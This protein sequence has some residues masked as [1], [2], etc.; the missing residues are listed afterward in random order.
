MQSYSDANKQRITDLNAKIRE[1]IQETTEI[2]VKEENVSRAEAE[3]SIGFQYEATS[4]VLIKRK[5]PYNVF[6]ERLAAEKKAEPHSGDQPR[7]SHFY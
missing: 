4:M 3:A 6:T 1:M 2:L 5:S 7:G